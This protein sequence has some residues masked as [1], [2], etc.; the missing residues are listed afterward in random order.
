MVERSR[1]VLGFSDEKKYKR[2]ESSSLIFPPPSSTSSNLSSTLKGFEIIEKENQI[3]SAI[4]NRLCEL[5]H[6]WKTD[7]F[8]DF[9]WTIYRG[10]TPCAAVSDQKSLR[11][12]NFNGGI[13]LSMLR[14]RVR[15]PRS[16][17]YDLLLVLIF[18]ML[19]DFKFR[20]FYAYYIM[21]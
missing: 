15:N 16:Y 8:E 17:K 5:T 6:P 9:M 1:I 18:Y 19:A 21:S 11:S 13:H 10:R 20:F 3:K 7:R 2:E 12:M 14:Y 4:R